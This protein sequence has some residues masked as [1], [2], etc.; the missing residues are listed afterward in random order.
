VKRTI[1]RA[2]K[3]SIGM[4]FLLLGAVGLVLPILQGVLFLFIGLAIL[5]TESRRIRALMEWLRGK[6]PRLFHGY[7]HVREVLHECREHLHLGKSLREI[8]AHFLKRLRNRR[9]CPGESDDHDHDTEET[10]NETK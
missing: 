9:K 10:E 7:D 4:F 1:K 2:L 6:F 3:I 5:S 8:A